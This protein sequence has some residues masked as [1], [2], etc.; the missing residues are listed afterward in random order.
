MHAEA[1]RAHAVRKLKFDKLQNTSKH[2]NTLEVVEVNFRRHGSKLYECFE[3]S[4]KNHLLNYDD[5]T[6]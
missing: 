2:F 3:L 6:N 5:N 4:C 1:S